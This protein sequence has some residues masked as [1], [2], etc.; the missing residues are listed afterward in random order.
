[1]AAPAAAVAAVLLLCAACNYGEVVVVEPA[2][3]HGPLAL[4]LLADPEDSAAARQLGWTTGIPGAEVTV[5]P[6]NADTA[7]GPPVATLQTDNAGRA[8]VAD[9]ADGHYLV[10]V[11]RLLTAAEIARLAPT[12]DVVGL[13]AQTIVARG[14]VTVPPRQPAPR[15]DGRKILQHTRSG[16]TDFYLAPRTPWEL[17]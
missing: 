13:M 2:A 11:R 5:S 10:E 17:P 12:E 7:A 16:I 4:L 9:L 1:V 8:S 6:A 3:A 14:S 15:S